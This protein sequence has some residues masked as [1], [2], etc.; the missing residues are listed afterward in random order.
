MSTLLRSWQRYWFRDSSLVDL[1]IVRIFVVGAQLWFLVSHNPRIPGFELLTGLPAELYDPLPILHLLVAP[2]DWNFRPSLELLQ[3][4]KGVTVGAGLLALV[5]WFTNPVLVLFALGNIFLQAHEYSYGNFH[6]T[7]AP[8]MIALVILAVSPAGRVLSVDDLRRRARVNARR[9]HFE[10]AR[11][12]ER[13]SRFAGWPLRLMQWI[14]AL[15]YLSAAYSKLR[16]GVDWM[17]GYTL[18]YYLIQDGLRWDS[19]LSLWLGTQHVPARLLSWGTVLLEG[20]FFL[21][22]LFP[23]LRWFYLPSGAA[24]HIGIQLTMRAPFMRWLALYGAFIPWSDALARI[25]GWWRRR[26][27]P[28]A[29]VYFDARCPLCLRIVTV[30]D[31]LDWAGRLRFRDLHTAGASLV[32]S[33]PDVGMA[34][35]GEEMHVVAGDETVRR[36]FV[37]FRYMAARLPVLWPLAL[38]SRLPG[39]GR[40][41]PSIYATVARSRSRAAGCDDGVCRIHAT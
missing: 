26:A 35:L 17:N 31:Y 30:L 29:D 12:L 38:L 2:I 4:V 18:Q 8:V 28:P 34:D 40:I 15:I 14:V 10:P 3:F 27:G 37:A 20:T 23:A 16:H 21:A 7:E 22:V 6:H 13:S 19:D 41:G 32:E 11:L 5:G 24:M 25:G 33:R 36:G 1:A 9:L 39:A